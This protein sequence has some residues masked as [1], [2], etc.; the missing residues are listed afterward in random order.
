MQP[1]QFDRAF[2]K[3]F[4]RLRDRFRNRPEVWKGA[5]DGKTTFLSGLGLGCLY[6]AWP[7]LGLL[8]LLGAGFHFTKVGLLQVMQRGDTEKLLRRIIPQSLA[9]KRKWNIPLIS[10]QM[11]LELNSIRGFVRGDPA[12]WDR[13]YR[14]R[15]LESPVKMFDC[16][17]E[18]LKVHPHV[19][20][21]LSQATGCPVF[22]KEIH[23]PYKPPKI[24]CRSTNG[25]TEIVMCFSVY[26][27]NQVAA[28]A[29]LK[30]LGPRIEY[31]YFFPEA[32]VTNQF[33]SFCIRPA[34][35]KK[36]W[37]MYRDAPEWGVFDEPKEQALSWDWE[38]RP[39]E[40]Y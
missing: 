38:E 34:S 6:N 18:A 5:I 33:P 8:C 35:M 28:E 26:V 39:F 40:K 16:A 32:S 22:G 15:D 23:V 13:H 21:A 1:E 9:K 30:S 20:K 2:N 27:G 14:N 7:K 10:N 19:H 17:V 4:F 37:D 12:Y 24:A 31:I 3:F 29:K 25:V 11:H 36:D